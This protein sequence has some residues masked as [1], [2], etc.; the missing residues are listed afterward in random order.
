[1]INEKKMDE[2][3]LELGHTENLLGTGYLRQAVA[4]YEGGARG[5]T[6]Q[7]YPAIAA[8]T[9]STP[10]QV[11]RNMRH[12]IEVAWARGDTDAQMRY[13]GNSVNPSSGRPTVSEYIARMARLCR[14]N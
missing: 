3:M 4:L 13:F 7:L 5:I 8:A 14:E 11:E 2:I 6:C 9:A 12:S 10:A 1:M